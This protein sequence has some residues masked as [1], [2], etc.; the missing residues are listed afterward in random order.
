[1]LYLEME[2][3]IMENVRKVCGDVVGFVLWIR[4]MVFFYGVNKE[5]FFLKVFLII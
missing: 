3:Y 2:D 5:V 4:V 1:M